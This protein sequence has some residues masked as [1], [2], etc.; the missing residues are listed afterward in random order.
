MG[1]AT[2]NQR[3]IY[4][5]N[6]VPSELCVL[7]CGIMRPIINLSMLLFLLLIPLVA[8][9]GVYN[10]DLAKAQNAFG[11][12]CAKMGLWDEA[13]MRWKRVVEM[14]PK[15]AQAHNNLGVA[16][17]SKGD[18]EA[19]RAEYKAA[20]ELDPDNKIY[21]SNYTRFK[22]NYDRVSKKNKAKKK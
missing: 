14:D 1:S 21:I 3:I 8:G 16:Y 9:C 4:I 18:F 2:Q 17:E 6:P 15:N 20:I 5:V 7:I 11:V 10:G 13:I 22:R 12:K 19:A